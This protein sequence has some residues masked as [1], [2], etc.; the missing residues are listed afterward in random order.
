MEESNPQDQP[1][2][3]MQKLRTDLAGLSVVA[4]AVQAWDAGDKFRE[5]VGN[6]LRQSEGLPVSRRVVEMLRDVVIDANHATT[7]AAWNQLAAKCRDLYEMFEAEHPA[8]PTPSEE[9]GHT[10]SGSDVEESP[11]E[12]IH[13]YARNEDRRTVDDM[14]ERSEVH[15]GQE[16]PRTGVYRTTEDGGSVLE[17]PWVAVVSE[18]GTYDD[19]SFAAGLVVGEIQERLRVG[20]AVGMTLSKPVQISKD[21]FEQVDLVA[22]RFGYVMLT[23]AA[24]DDP[25]YDSGFV[26]FTSDV[27]HVHDDDD[28]DDSDSG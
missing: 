1:D 24:W 3:S 22:M 27:P 10:D 14:P 9:K 15:P 20:Q 25:Q 7:T 8:D 5:V 13:R 17:Q 16:V 21:L 4:P 11:T 2:V 28:H 26:R 18:G 12:V 23:S 6:M 19:E